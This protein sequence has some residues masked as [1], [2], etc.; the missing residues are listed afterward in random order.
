MLHFFEVQVG[1]LN[2]RMSR[3]FG[4]LPRRLLVMQQFRRWTHRPALIHRRPPARLDR[5]Q[6]RRGAEL[7]R[8][9]HTGQQIVHFLVRRAGMFDVNAVLPVALVRGARRR[10]AEVAVV[11]HV[12]LV[13][14]RV[15]VAR[16]RVADLGPLALFRQTDRRGS[17]RSSRT[18]L[19]V[20]VD[21]LQLLL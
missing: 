4:P 8:G 15:F 19:F 6:G 12:F 21:H 18:F 17:E 14:R 7:H 3:V 11:R 13:L 5:L 16:V 20:A 1:P 9:G 2:M 10:R